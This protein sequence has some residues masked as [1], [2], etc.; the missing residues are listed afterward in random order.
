M[1]RK[2]MVVA[3]AGLV[4]VLGCAVAADTATGHAGPVNPTGANTGCAKPGACSPQP[5]QTKTG[6]PG[7]TAAQLTDCIQAHGV[8]VPRSMPLKTWLQSA[9]A[10]PNDSNALTACGLDAGS[11]ISK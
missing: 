10:D 9:V 6:S 3:L 11:P 2:P 5:K 1:H 8:T 4:A 7:P